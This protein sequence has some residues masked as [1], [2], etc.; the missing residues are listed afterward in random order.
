MTSAA[1]ASTSALDAGVDLGAGAV[2]LGLDAGVDLGG[3]SVDVGLDAGV[4]LGGGTVDLGLDAGV[5]LGGASRRPRARHGRRP[6]RRHRR[7]RSRRRRRPR[8]RR[9]RRRRRRPRPRRRT[10]DTG[11]DTATSTS[12]W[13][14][15]GDTGVDL[16][17]HGRPRRWTSAVRSIWTSALDLDLGA[18]TLDSA[19][20]AA[21]RLL[22]PAPPAPPPPPR[23]S[24]RP[25]RRPALARGDQAIAGSFGRPWR[26]RFS[27][28]AYT[29]TRAGT[30]RA[31]RT[32]SPRR[33]RR[34][35]RTSATA[36]SSSSASTRESLRALN[37]WPWPRRHHARLL[38]MLRPAAPKTCS[39]TSTSA[40]ARPRKTTRCSSAR[41]PSG[42]HAGLP[43]APLP[44]AQRRRQ[45]A[46]RDAAAAA[47]RAHAE[48][49]SVMLE[50][51]ADGLVRDMRSSWAVDGETLAVGLR[52]RDAAARGHGRPDRLLDRRLLVRLRLVHRRRERPRRSRRAAR[53]DR[54]RRAR[55]RS[56]S[57]TS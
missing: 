40:R 13:S 3:A 54:L 31:S 26:W 50:P 20:A 34:C 7:P 32:P 56:S 17:R 44:G 57:A 48:L 27:A 4:D 52:A 10:V 11:L 28:A 19:S 38:Q 42:R 5:D 46:D 43:R 1:A 14:T 24:R 9:R 37:E 12:V 51:G 8:R 6:R 23:G 21:A 16:G 30:S 41:S 55:R 2:D 33:A 45:L 35:S 49:A 36:T 15:L 53:Q 25:A 22:R 29:C 18:G 39:S 47:V